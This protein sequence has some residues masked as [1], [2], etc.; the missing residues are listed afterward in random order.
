MSLSTVSI[1]SVLPLGSSELS[2]VS[3]P[4]RT[5]QTHHTL[6]FLVQGAVPPYCPLCT[7]LPFLPT[8]LTWLC[9]H[10]EWTPGLPLSPLSSVF[11]QFQP[12]FA[13]SRPYTIPTAAIFFFLVIP[14]VPS[15]TLLLHSLLFPESQGIHRTRLPPFTKNT[16]TLIPL[17]LYYE[18]LTSSSRSPLWTPATHSQ[19]VFH[20]SP[21]SKQTNPLTSFQSS[22]SRYQFL[23]TITWPFALLIRLKFVQLLKIK[24]VHQ[25]SEPLHFRFRQDF[26]HFNFFKILPLI[27]NVFFLPTGITTFPKPGL[28]VLIF[29]TLCWVLPHLEHLLTFSSHLWNGDKESPCLVG[30]YVDWVC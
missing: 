1:S 18:S 12:F 24:F 7:H 2:V 30:Y 15:L 22:Q 6:S 23:S 29:L 9:P 28:S 27:S 19:P 16:H 14:S 8:P 26:K 21:I 20:L 5:P 17:L 4:L 13:H 10:W 3:S 11:C 25:K